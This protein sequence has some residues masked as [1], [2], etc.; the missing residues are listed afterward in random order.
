MTLADFL[1]NPSG[2]GDTALNTKAIAS[3]LDSKYE[4]L[5]DNK[6]DKIVCKVYKVLAKE[7]YYVHLIIPTETERTNTYDVVIELSDLEGSHRND[8]SI[9]R[10]D[11]RFFSNTPSFAYTYAKVYLDND[12]LIPQLEDKFED[13]QISQNPD[14]RNRFGIVGYDKYLYF[15]VKY[16][17]E[18]KI[19]NKLTL[20]YRA[21]RY[22]PMLFI[23][24]IRTS[25]KIIQEY[26][27]A[28]RVLRKE[29]GKPPLKADNVHS[30][31]RTNVKND[32]T[33]HVVQPKRP[34][35]KIG[36]KAKSCARILKK[37]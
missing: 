24:K 6:G 7:V 35:N 12:L 33:V 10:Y 28:N 21:L 29:Q 19:L 18:S 25:E 8:S 34:V 4:R 9:A 26:H 5:M 27:R 15:G 3:M 17:Y 16:V 36:S 13:E 20:G 11:A 2:K 37:K 32:S 22:N 31:I 30:K 1:S 23:P 14:T